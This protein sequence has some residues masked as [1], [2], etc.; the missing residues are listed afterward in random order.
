MVTVMLEKTG[1]VNVTSKVLKWMALLTVS[2][3]NPWQ[4]KPKSI[5]LLKM[6]CHPSFATVLCKSMMGSSRG[7]WHFKNFG[8][9]ALFLTKHMANYM[10][11]AK[12]KKCRRNGSS[13]NGMAKRSYWEGLKQEEPEMKYHWQLSASHFAMVC[14]MLGFVQRLLMG[15][16]PSLKISSHESS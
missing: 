3:N 11:F 14:G 7:C 1:T 6:F 13:N 8:K 2:Y 12:K 10:D 5:S 15:L 9:S 16:P 4:L